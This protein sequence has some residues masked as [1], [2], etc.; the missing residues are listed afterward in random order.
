MLGGHLLADTV[1]LPFLYDIEAHVRFLVALPPRCIA[2][3]AAAGRANPAQLHTVIRY[4]DMLIH[5]VLL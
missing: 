2:G 1:K 5:S 3:Y 4:R